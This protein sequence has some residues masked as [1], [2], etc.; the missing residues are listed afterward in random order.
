MDESLD[1]RLS[2]GS[3]VHHVEKSLVAI[4]LARAFYLCYLMIE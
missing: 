2:L 4:D 3:F 1:F